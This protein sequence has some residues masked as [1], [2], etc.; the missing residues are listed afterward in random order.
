MWFTNGKIKSDLLTI[1]LLYVMPIIFI[2]DIYVMFYHQNSFDPT[3]IS[4]RSTVR[5][6]ANLIFLLF[7][8]FVLFWFTLFCFVLFRLA[9]F[10]FFVVCLYLDKKSW[11]EK[12]KTYG[13]HIS[14][15]LVLNILNHSSKNPPESCVCVCVWE[16]KPAAVTQKIVYRQMDCFKMFNL[17]FEKSSK[18]IWIGSICIRDSSF[19]N[20]RFQQQFRLILIFYLDA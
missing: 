12:W 13:E 17:T 4:V 18:S 2:F 9:W 1:M 5:P 14:N 20:R 10:I 16:Q 6:F 7:F 8:I 11:P 19:L 15:L 3:V